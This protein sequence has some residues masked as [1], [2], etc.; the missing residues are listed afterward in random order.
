MNISRR[1][2]GEEIPFLDLDEKSGF[3]SRLFG[4]KRRKN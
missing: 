1:I 4:G 2:L 3:F